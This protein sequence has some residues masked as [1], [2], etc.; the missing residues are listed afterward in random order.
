MC[1]LDAWKEVLAQ[2]QT[3]SRVFE[4]SD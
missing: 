3:T 1:G 4:Q 2:K